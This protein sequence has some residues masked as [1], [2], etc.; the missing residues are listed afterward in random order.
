MPALS[1]PEL[2]QL[3]ILTLSSTS[4]A[5]LPLVLVIFV[6]IGVVGYT[7][8]YPYLG[9][10]SPADVREKTE[11]MMEDAKAT[12]DVL[13]REHLSQTSDEEEH[14][15]HSAAYDA[16]FQRHL[17]DLYDEHALFLHP[18]HSFR[19]WWDAGIWRSDIGSWV[20][21]MKIAI[22][23]KQLSRSASSPG[24]GSRA[25][26]TNTL[27]NSDS[28]ISTSASSVSAGD[29]MPSVN[30]GGETYLLSL[31]Q[32]PS[33]SN[34]GGSSAPSSEEDITNSV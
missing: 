30:F 15:R 8:V 26:S 22:K 14:R 34:R 23:K 29:V 12:Y 6:F 11:K 19:F 25:R 28:N 33:S 4:L 27:T 5:R 18:M 10:Y 31:V 16:L 1:I 2:F 9:P 13:K 3:L 20:N 7:L 17:S 21:Q 32:S 24:L